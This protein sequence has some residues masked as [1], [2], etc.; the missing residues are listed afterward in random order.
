MPKARWPVRAVIAVV[1]AAL[2]LATSACS[3]TSRSSAPV[4]VHTARPNIVFVLTDDQRWDTIGQMPW[5]SHQPGWATFT[6]SFIEDPQCCPS[7]ATILTGRDT[8]HTGVQTLQDGAKLDERTTVATMLHAAGYRTGL[9]GKYLN[10]YP[11]DRGR[12]VPP[13]W[14]TWGA[15]IHSTLYYKYQLNENGKAVRYGSDPASYS[16]D[17]LSSMARRFI[18]TTPRSKPLFLYLAYNAPHFVG[19]GWAQPAR[20][21]IGKCKSLAPARPPSYNLVDRSNSPRWLWGTK[22]QT[23]WIMDTQRQA[24]CEAMLDV[25]RQ[26]ASLVRTLRDTGRL[27]DTYLL[28]ASDN[29]YHYGEHRLVGKGDLYE[30]S[31]RVPLMA[32]GPGIAGRPIARLTSN[33]DWT[34]TMLDWAGVQAPKGFLDGQSFAGNLRGRGGTLPTAVLLRGCRTVMT[35]GGSSDQEDSSC[36]GYPSGFG[37]AWGIRTARYVY[38]EYDDGSRELYDVSKDPYEIDDLAGRPA[39]A[40]VQRGLAS[41]LAARRGR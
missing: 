3:S 31:I 36:G 28:F 19:Y 18:T 11:F 5:L 29:G 34:P 40:G 22:P 12:Y 6:N 13:G 4:V 33:L 10:G 17:V 8:T 38:V 27:D 14:D 37:L 24:A 25:D 21:D 20:R 23:D 1:A 26:L 16:T 41:E 35:P 7:R 30:E 32:K 2:L 9:F 39:Y 15:Y